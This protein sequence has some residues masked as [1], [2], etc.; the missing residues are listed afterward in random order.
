MQNSKFSIQDICSIAIMT[1]I[2]AV[3]AQISIPMPL[4]VPMTMQTF[5]ITLAGIVLGSKKGGMSIL[6]YVLLGAIGV[7][8]FAGFSG[9]FQNLVGPTGGFIISFPIMAYLIGLG[10]ELKKKELFV[11]FLVLGT[12]SNY[13]VGVIL[14]CVVT[15]SPVATGI[16]AC[17]LPFI[18]TAIIKAVVA[19]VLGLE[20]RKRL[21]MVLQCA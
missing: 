21:G 5:A 20:L 14:F 18:P 6:V 2:T 7:P 4:G 13:V 3:M 10:V 1:A 9:G 11:L 16:T 15:Q 19:S 8:V 17:V 12:V